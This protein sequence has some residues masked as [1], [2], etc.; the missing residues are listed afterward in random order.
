MRGS[1]RERRGLDTLKI[2]KFQ[3][4]GEEKLRMCSNNYHFTLFTEQRADVLRIQLSGLF[5][6][7]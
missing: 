2:D 5:R 6:A 4:V 3:R 7:P 1:Y